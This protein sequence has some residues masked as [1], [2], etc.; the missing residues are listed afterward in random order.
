M[1]TV[2]AP[3]VMVDPPQQRAGEDVVEDNI[4]T[5]GNAHPTPVNYEVLVH[6]CQGQLSNMLMDQARRRSQVA[7]LIRAMQA[8]NQEH[9]RIAQLLHRIQEIMDPEFAPGMP[10]HGFRAP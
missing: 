9:E 7:E 3:D 2:E 1:S 4:G 5:D 8:W 6:T 10:L